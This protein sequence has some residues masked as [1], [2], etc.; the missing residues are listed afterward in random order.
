[1]QRCCHCHGRFGLVTHR[2]LFRRF[3]SRKC[4][5]TH[6]RDLAAAV[7]AR[8]SHWGSALLTSIALAKFL[9][10][11][12]AANGTSRYVQVPSRPPQR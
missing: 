9:V 8:V 7:W 10:S 12:H 3:C 5:D 1:M 4:L 2:H 11:S 6:K